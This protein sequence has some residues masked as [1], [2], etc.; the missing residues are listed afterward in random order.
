ME[1]RGIQMSGLV[2]QIWESPQAEGPR[3]THGED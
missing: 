1:K 3:K 2:T